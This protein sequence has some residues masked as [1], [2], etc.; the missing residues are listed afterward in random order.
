MNWKKTFNELIENEQW[1][2]ALTFIKNVVAANP[3]DAESMIQCIY[4]CHYILLEAHNVSLDFR[5]IESD[6][7]KYFRLGNNSFSDSPEY[8][9][10]IGNI[11]FIGEWLFGVDDDL[12]LMEERLA[13]KMM[14]KAYQLEPDNTLY[15]WG[16]TFLMDVKSASLIAEQILKKEDHRVVWLKSKGSFGDYIL[17]QLERNVTHDR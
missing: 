8:L 6:L 12:K 4:L 9:F 17:R 2:A 3:N 14:K 10:F 7:K 1:E 13:F 15:K 5:K 11:L 16:Y